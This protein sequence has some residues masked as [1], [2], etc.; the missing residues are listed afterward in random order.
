MA[1]PEYNS[2]SIINT[3]DET[4]RTNGVNAAQ[5]VYKSAL[6]DWVDDVT[7]GDTIDKESVKGEI[8]N[9]WLAYAALNKRS[10]LVSRYCLIVFSLLTRC[11]NL[12]FGSC[13]YYD[14]N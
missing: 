7:M 8:A 10:N 13:A 14:R 1:P 6:L 12:E 4:L 2:Q 3:A 5:T 9:L 11:C